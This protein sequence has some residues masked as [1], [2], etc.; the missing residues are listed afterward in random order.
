MLK[1][2]GR[3]LDKDP[4]SW[5]K[6]VRKN[7]KLILETLTEDDFVEIFTKTGG[8]KMM[9]EIPNK[10]LMYCRWCDKITE[11]ELDEAYE[12]EAFYAC[13][14]CGHIRH[15]YYSVLREIAIPIEE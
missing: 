7:V 10:V 2:L 11:H 8:G 1:K 3:I 9:D 12:E 4:D 14:K 5:I 15:V 6:T 13:V